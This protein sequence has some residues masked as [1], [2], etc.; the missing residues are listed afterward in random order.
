M[1]QQWVCIA[2][3][4]A[5]IAVRNGKRVPTTVICKRSGDIVG[6]KIRRIG[7]VKNIDVLVVR[8]SF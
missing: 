4:T 8:R 7:C 2:E 1:D 5:V 3:H 6:E